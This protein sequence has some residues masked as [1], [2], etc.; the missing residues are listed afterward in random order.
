MRIV[1]TC[2]LIM[3]V[4]TPA[5]AQDVGPRLVPF[6][7]RLTDTSGTTPI[8]DG[9]YSMV[10]T[11]WDSGSGGNSLAVDVHPSVSVIGGFVN[12][13]LGSNGGLD[14]P[15]SFAAPRYLGIKIGDGPEMVPRHELVPAFH[16]RT[17]ETSAHAEL[18]DTAAFAIDAD[19]LDGFHASALNNSLDSAYDFGASGAG[20]RIT[21]NAG[22][23][24]IDGNDG[25][26]VQGPVGFGTDSPAAGTNLHISGGFE[27]ARV[28][29][30]ADTNNAGEDDQPS[31]V[32]TQDG[33]AVSGK[34]GY[35][36]LGNDFTISQSYASGELNLQTQDLTR[37]TIESNGEVGIGT[38][39]PSSLLHVAGDIRFDGHIQGFSLSQQYSVT[40]TVAPGTS[41]VLMTPTSHSVC[42][43]HQVRMEELDNGDEYAECDIDP[44]QGNWRLEA[45]LG[46]GAPGGGSEVHCQARC[47]SW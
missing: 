17:A 38:Q 22:A 23:V 24:E 9:V 40:Q 29:I 39:D 33:G 8:P 28:L 45:I 27:S 34:I 47:L 3:L 4:L 7:A 26:L 30:E 46:P 43:L 42:F 15:F 13:L 37:L 25:L 14:H 35:F 36:D 11:V 12:V 5:L 32:F 41:F 18:A 20:R 21:A 1:T 19:K 10:F 44:H 6:Q 16:A 2:A 31:L